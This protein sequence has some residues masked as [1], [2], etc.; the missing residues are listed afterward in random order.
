LKLQL[1]VFTLLIA[2]YIVW[3]I[4]ETAA[5]P[6]LDTNTLLLLGVSQGTYIGGKLSSGTALNRAQTL[7][8]DMDL[9]KDEIVDLT[10]KK[11]KLTTEKTNLDQVQN[12]TKEQNEALA[13]VTKLIDEIDEQISAANKKITELK[14][15]LKRIVKEELELVTD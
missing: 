7:K 9:K 4:M 10:E 13:A 14:E 8:L 1:L 15:S 12:K 2:S 6:E 3:R 5:F 11:K